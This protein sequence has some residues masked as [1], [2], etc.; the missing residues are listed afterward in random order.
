M[1]P[2]DVLTAHE[3]RDIY[4]YS[5]SHLLHS[6]S[7]IYTNGLHFVV[8]LLGFVLVDFS[9]IRQGYVTSKP[10]KFVPVGPIINISASVLIMSWRWPGDKPLSEPIMVRLP[11]HICIPQPQWFIQLPGKHMW[12]LWVIKSH[13]PTKNLWHLHNNANKA[14]PITMILDYTGFFPDTV[15]ACAT[16]KKCNFVDYAMTGK[17]LLHTYIYIYICPVIYAYIY[18]YI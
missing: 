6:S 8:V 2:T 15:H 10:L 9:Q 11:T 13:K 5:T 12:H 7:Q 4:V 3:W 1:P 17:A 14:H 16:I 18:V